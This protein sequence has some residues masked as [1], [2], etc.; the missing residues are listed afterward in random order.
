[1]QRVRANVDN[2][3]HHQHNRPAASDY[4]LSHRRSRISTVAWVQRATEGG[5]AADR[6]T[7]VTGNTRPLVDLRLGLAQFC[8]PW[9]SRPCSPAALF[10]HGD[11]GAE[12]EDV[13]LVA[14]YTARALALRCASITSSG[15]IG[16]LMAGST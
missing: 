16:G 8:S 5:Q 15:T 9:R 3:R 12:G 13:F 1:M 11:A 7:I 4:G 6:A 14:A 10:M 2:A